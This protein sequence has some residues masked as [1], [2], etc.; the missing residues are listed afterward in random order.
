MLQ[1][2]LYKVHIAEEF[3]TWLYEKYPFMQLTLVPGSCTGKGQVGDIVLYRPIKHGLKQ[4]FVRWSADETQKLL[5]AAKAANGGGSV[6]ISKI[7]LNLSVGPLR[8]LTVGWAH[9]VWLEVKAMPGLVEK[10]FQMAGTDKAWEPACQRAAVLEQPR[11]FAGVDN[12]GLPIRNQ[13][14]VT[15]LGAVME[16]QDEDPGFMEQDDEDIPLAQWST[17]LRAAEAAAAASGSG[18]EGPGPVVTI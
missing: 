1:Y 12:R 10:G 5:N 11:L 4:E 16:R 18:S 14:G 8:E 9:K 7:K 15:H 6:D 3:W 17:R 13:Q 2:D